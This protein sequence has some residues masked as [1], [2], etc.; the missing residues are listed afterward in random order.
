MGLVEV[1]GLE[2]KPGALPRPQTA[3]GHDDH[4][5][6]QPVRYGVDELADLFAGEWN[7]DSADAGSSNRFQPGRPGQYLKLHICR[8]HVNKRRRKPDTGGLMRRLH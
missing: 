6:P 3:A 8:P 4:E 5:R 1:D 7:A 2:G